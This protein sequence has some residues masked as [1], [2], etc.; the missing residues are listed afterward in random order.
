MS[1]KS[2]ITLAIAAVM[3]STVHAAPAVGHDNLWQD[4][5]NKVYS[6]I[7]YDLL[8]GPTSIENDDVYYIT[9]F[10]QC[11]NGGCTYYKYKWRD[12]NKYVYLGKEE[13]QEVHPVQEPNQWVVTLEN[14]E[15][16]G[17]LIGGKLIV[18]TNDSINPIQSKD[19]RMTVNHGKCKLTSPEGEKAYM[20]QQYGGAW[21]YEVPQSC[22]IQDIKLFDNQGNEVIWDAR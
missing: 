16:N 2:I 15:V 6:G 22:N 1:I 7:E 13:L 3:S 20:P 17:H 8:I 11:H 14:P 18:L 4:Y 5:Y 12:D 21:L 19:L 10:D 9:T